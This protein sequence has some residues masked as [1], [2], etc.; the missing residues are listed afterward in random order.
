[1]S[2]IL[3]DRER[4][5]RADLEGRGIRNARVLAAFRLIPR[6][7]FVPAELRDAAYKDGPLSIGRGQTISQPF[8]VA[9]M[10]EALKLNGGERVLE[11]GTGSGYSAALL[12]CLAPEVDTIER[13]SEL[14]RSARA[15]LIA[16]GFERIRVHERDGTLGLPERAPFDAIVVAAGGPYAP[17]ALLGQ[18]APDGRLVMPVG[19]LRTDQ[20]LVRI[21]RIDTERFETQDL[22]RV[23]F[24]PLIGAQGWGGV[25]SPPAS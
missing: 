7:N 9:E 8:M 23:R 10:L 1:M 2:E 13:D 11:V 24:V 4:M 17:R 19:A 22:G 5:V 6:E 16:Q 21:T 18:L 15:R 20:R 14:A 25:E 12:S 3:T